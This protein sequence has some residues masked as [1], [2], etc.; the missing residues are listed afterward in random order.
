MDERLSLERADGPEDSQAC[1]VMGNSVSAWQKHYDVNCT[2]RGT[3]AGVDQTAV[4]RTA[5]LER[6]AVVVDLSSGV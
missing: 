4:W 6:S 2:I 3:Q 1:Q 5:M